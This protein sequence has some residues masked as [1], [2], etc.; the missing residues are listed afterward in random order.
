M[1]LKCT[2]RKGVFDRFKGPTQPG[3]VLTKTH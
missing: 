3:C 2:N 1:A